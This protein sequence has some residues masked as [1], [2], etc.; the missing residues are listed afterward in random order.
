MPYNIDRFKLKSVSLTLPK[1]FSMKDFSGRAWDEIQVDADLETWEYNWNN[2][3]FQ[4]RGNVTDD[5]LDVQEI[6]CYGEGSG[7]DY[8]SL[9]LPLFKKFEGGLEASLVW[10][11]GDSITRNSIKKGVVTEEEIDI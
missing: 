4:M 7:S 3:G 11:G 6:T 10:G 9:L 5:G 8:H 2:E 1:S